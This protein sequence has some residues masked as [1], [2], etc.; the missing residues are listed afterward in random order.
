[1][2]KFFEVEIIVT[3]KLLVEMEDNQT[4]EMALTVAVEESSFIGDVT[5]KNAKL[6]SGVDLVKSR[7]HCCDTINL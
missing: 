6:V 3:A 7:Q 5:A 4:A 1:M 2:S